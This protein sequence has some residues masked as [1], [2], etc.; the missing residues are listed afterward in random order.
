MY[1]SNSTMFSYKKSLSPL[2]LKSYC[3]LLPCISLLDSKAQIIR[4]TNKTDASTIDIYERDFIKCRFTIGQAG[5]FTGGGLVRHIDDSSLIYQ[6]R[7]GAHRQ[8]K[9]ASIT[10]IDR[11]AFKRNI[12]PCIVAGLVAGGLDAAFNRKNNTTTTGLMLGGA[13]LLEFNYVYIWNHRR[14]NKNAVPSA[15]QLSVNREQ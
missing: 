15:V 11:V 4:V 9:L 5:Q 13:I 14:L 1:I 3:F 2:I 6:S 12:V 8:V 10:H 7:F